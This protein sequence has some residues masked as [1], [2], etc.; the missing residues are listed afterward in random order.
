MHPDK[1][2]TSC[3][4]CGWRRRCRGGK[5]GDDVSGR[6]ALFAEGPKAEGVVA[7]GEAHAGGVQHQRGVEKLRSGSVKRAEEQELAKGAFHEVS[8]ANDF[9]D[10]E[11]GVVHGAGELVAGHAVFAPHEKVA[12]VA[13]GGSGLGAEAVVVKRE[14]LAGGD[15]EAPVDGERVGERWE[16]G[17]GGRAELGRVDWFIIGCG[18]GTLV[19]RAEGIEDIAAG[20][21]TGENGAGGVELGE[22]GAVERETR[23]LADDGLGPGEAEPTQVFE[24]GGDEIEAETDGVEV[25]VAEKQSAAGGAGALGSEPK[26]AGVAEVEVPGG[27]RRE[28]SAIGRECAGRGVR[29]AES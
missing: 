5:L 1:A 23:A 17:V 6:F 24:H 26:R 28:A 11:I 19:G 10:P 22:G 3:G 7:F 12:E 9:G 21:G 14:G 2:G 13:A 16:R 25:V 18:R 4:G 27:R 29:R 20:A 15:A 8:P